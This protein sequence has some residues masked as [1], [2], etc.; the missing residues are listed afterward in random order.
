MET[1]QPLVARC[2]TGCGRKRLTQ[3]GPCNYCG[4]YYDP[5][6]VPP[7]PGAVPLLVSAE[8]EDDGV[9]DKVRKRMTRLI[10]DAKYWWVAAFLPFAMLFPIPRYLLF[11]IALAF[12]P[13]LVQWYVWRRLPG[14]PPANHQLTR[15]YNAALSR[16]WIASLLPILAFLTLLVSILIH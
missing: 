13:R 2:C 14:F 3:D 8:K 10:S 5:K 16:L 9:P 4:A 7:E 12:V 15:E 6:A 11:L 1:E